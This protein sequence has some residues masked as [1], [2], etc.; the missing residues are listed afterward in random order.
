MQTN[1]TYEVI[2]AHKSN[3]PNPI[4]LQKGERVLVGQTYKD[5][6]EWSNW[7]YCHTVEGNLEGWVP[8]QIID[9]EVVLESYSAKELTIEIGETVTEERELNGWLWVKKSKDADQGWVP[10]ENLELLR[11]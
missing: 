6:P 1:Q 3:Y 2:K 4:K 9:E 8:E 11:T 10:K 5:N 7:I